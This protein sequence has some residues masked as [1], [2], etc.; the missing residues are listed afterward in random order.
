MTNTDILLVDDDP[1]ALQATQTLLTFLGYRSRALSDPLTALQAISNAPPRLLITDVVMPGMNG[2]ELA[3]KA[4]NLHPH[5][6]VIY[7]TGYSADLLE[8]AG[9]PPTHVLLKP[10]SVE[11][12]QQAIEECLA[13]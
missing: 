3:T 9:E 13:A 7:L 6:R 11:A 2:V 1:D 12:L 5:I 10:W 8:A 4:R